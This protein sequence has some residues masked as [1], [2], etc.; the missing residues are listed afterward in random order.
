MLHVPLCIVGN[1]IQAPDGPGSMLCIAQ[2]LYFS[3]RFL[4][5]PYTHKQQNG[6]NFQIQTGKVDEPW[7]ENLEQASY[8]KDVWDFHWVLIWTCW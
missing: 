3:L 7:W 1:E 4:S 8:V 6:A 2:A 5:E